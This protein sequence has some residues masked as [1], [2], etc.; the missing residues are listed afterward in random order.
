MKVLMKY[1][2][3]IIWNHTVRYYKL[4]VYYL[5]Y[6]WQTKFRGYY[7]PYKKYQSKWQ[8]KVSNFKFRLAACEVLDKTLK[9][10]NSACLAHHEDYELINHIFVL[11]NNGE[12]RC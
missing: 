12:R 9:N 7:Y 2:K 4:I 5:Y 11:N 1:I 8:E 6:H 3:N 10:F